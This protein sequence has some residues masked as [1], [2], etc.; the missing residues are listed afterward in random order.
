MGAYARK[1]IF[2][3]FDNLSLMLTYNPEIDKEPWVDES[4][5]HLNGFFPDKN[6]TNL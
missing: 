1:F 2:V 5:W 4:D 3:N 6:R